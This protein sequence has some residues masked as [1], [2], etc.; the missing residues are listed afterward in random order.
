M[1]FK[2]LIL[3]TVTLIC[4]TVCVVVPIRAIENSGELETLV[5]L[6][7]KV[8]DNYYEI[9]GYTII[10]NN[11]CS[12]KEGEYE[13]SYQSLEDGMVY[14][15]KVVV[16]SLDD[17]E[18]FNIE[19]TDIKAFRDYPMILEKSVSLSE[20]EQILLV[21]YITDA[22]KK[23][24]HLY[25]YYLKNQEIVQEL[26][27][28]YNQEVYVNDVLTD[29]SEFVV[30]G[31]IW[32]S[33]YANYDIVLV[34]C[35]KSGFRKCSKMIGGSKTDTA[36]TGLALEDGYLIVGKTESLDQ[37]FEG[38]KKENTFI[39]KVDKENYNVKNIEYY[40]YYE[41]LIQ[42][43]ILKS[44][45]IYFVY[46]HTDKKWELIQ[47]SSD[48]KKIK[49]KEITFKESVTIKD[50]Y[51]LDNQMR[52]I[53]EKDDGIE[54]GEINLKGYSKSY[55]K[56]LD[57]QIVNIGIN[58]ASITFI[59]QIDDGYKIEVIDNDFLKIYE[60][61]VYQIFN[62]NKLEYL[63]QVIIEDV[64]N[65]GK[66]RV[67]TLEYLKILSLGSN[68]VNES[69]SKDYVVI[70]NGKRCEHLKGWDNIDYNCFGNYEITY[71]FDENLNLM[72]VKPV[73]VESICQI[74]E[75]NIYDLG[76]TIN[77]NGIAY[78]NNMR[79][80]SGYVINEEGTYL[81]EIEGKNNAKETINFEVRN[82]SLKGQIKE[83][84][85]LIINTKIETKELK[86]EVLSY[87]IILN[88]ESSSKINNTWDFMY[89]IPALIT[90]GV[91]FMIIKMK[92]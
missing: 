16:I 71:Y 10:Q 4:L 43:K 68:Q 79:I 60:K 8:D 49:T 36:I 28:F 86:E 27:L 12:E 58:S 69:N 78:L 32:N 20:N 42:A 56:N 17:K 57:Y 30:I 46:P 11:V 34:V 54:I 26:Q 52:V 55:E 90:L 14:S 9:P 6:E 22:N 37:V 67:H 87:N 65:T 2:I 82:L 53:L 1:K 35:D 48:G 83:E 66:I 84:S 72:M 33:L 44:E 61:D 74:T 40:T 81:L 88:E 64:S 80:E 45:E 75:N 50:I 31:Q 47:I 41:S 38:N 3:M 59:Y 23:I 19:T 91:G 76:V 29:G 85:E 89:T 73:K 51:T 70:I 77:H 92:Y 39:M 7:G 24:G 5:I 13:I 62:S 18:Y 25:M 15:R 21:R 63:N